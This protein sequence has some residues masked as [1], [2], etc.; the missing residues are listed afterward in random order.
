MAISWSKIEPRKP[1]LLEP[2]IAKPRGRPKMT[3]PVIEEPEIEYVP[4][5]PQL[6]VST[7]P[8]TV[9]K[10]VKPKGMTPERLAIGGTESAEQKALFCQCARNVGKYPELKW[11][12]AIPNGGTRGD[13]PELRAIRGGQLVAEGVRSGV[14]DTCLPV[15]RACYSGLYI[16]MKKKSAKPKKETSKGGLSDE[17]I[18]FGEFVKKQ[19]YAWYCCYGWQEA[20]ACVE[21]YINLT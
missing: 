6:K 8:E 2:K 10:E 11:F 19:D 20:W 9:T 14:A 12:F 21:W 17:Q 18:E 15:K 16:E 5:V 3:K 4:F 1:K 7:K 13:T